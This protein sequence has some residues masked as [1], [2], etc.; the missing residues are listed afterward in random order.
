MDLRKNAGE[1][2]FGAPL[3]RDRGLAR[4]LQGCV[5]TSARTRSS[6]AS[7]L[8][9]LANFGTGTPARIAREEAQ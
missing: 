2:A 1:S 9:G 3:A 7:A 6:H 4:R 8:Q 5:G